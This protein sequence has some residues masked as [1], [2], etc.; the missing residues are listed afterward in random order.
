MPLGPEAFLVAV[1][2][3]T[4]C[5]EKKKQFC[6][7]C[8]LSFL[9]GVHMER[10]CVNESKNTREKTPDPAKEELS[11]VTREMSCGLSFERGLNPSQ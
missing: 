3:I 10:K 7:T 1:L 5:M 2:M 4:D 11:K 8:S 6:Q 9:Q